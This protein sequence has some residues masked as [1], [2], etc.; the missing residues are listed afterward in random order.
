MMDEIRKKKLL[1]QKCISVKEKVAM[2]D[3]LNCGE[4]V[5]DTIFTYINNIYFLINFVYM[6]FIFKILSYLIKQQHVQHNLL[7]REIMM[8]VTY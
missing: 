2:L 8:R 1:K 6:P 7:Q 5:K 4:K 3:Q